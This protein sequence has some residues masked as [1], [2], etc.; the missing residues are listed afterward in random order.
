[1][2]APQC[3]RGCLVCILPRVSWVMLSM[4]T[5]TPSSM[6]WMK[7]RSQLISILAPFQIVLSP[8]HDPIIQELVKSG[9]SVIVSGTGFSLDLFKMVLASSVGKTCTTWAVHYETGDFSERETQLAYLSQ[10]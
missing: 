3:S 5:S 8:W 6:C 10:F 9:S 1:M 2:R 4:R 7:P